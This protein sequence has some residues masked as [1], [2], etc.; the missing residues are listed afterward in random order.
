[1]L[2]RRTTWVANGEKRTSSGR[3]YCLPQWRMTDAVEKVG[4][5]SGKLRW[6]D[7]SLLARK[8]LLA[9]GL[10]DWRRRRG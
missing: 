4:V 1:M 9:L 3:R 2:H 7:F 10:P 5:T 8:W 6:S